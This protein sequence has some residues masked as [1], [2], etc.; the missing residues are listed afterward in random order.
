M[1]LLLLIPGLMLLSHCGPAPVN[2]SRTYEAASATVYMAISA[3][4]DAKSDL[5]FSPSYA[6]TELNICVKS[7]DQADTAGVCILADKAGKYFKIGNIE[8]QHQQH[9]K[10]TGTDSAGSEQVYAFEVREAG[11]E[12]AQPQPTISAI[13]ESMNFAVTAADGAKLK[14]GDVFKK[15]YMIVELSAYDCGPCRAF[16]QDFNRNGRQYES[17]FEKGQCSKM[18]MVDTYGGLQGRFPNWVAMLGGP[19]S[20]LGKASYTSGLSLSEAARKLGFTEQFGIPTLIM[21]DRTGKVI[22]AA[23]GAMPRKAKQLCVQ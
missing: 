18:V 15:K 6:T 7:P 9:F 21:V 11:K 23:S 2:A 12:D 10:V 1:R 8:L 13:P 14:V 22:D 17:L 20:Y 19:T 4:T 5:F 16:A 3:S